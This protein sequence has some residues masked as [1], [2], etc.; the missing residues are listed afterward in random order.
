LIH[1]NAPR[2]AEAPGFEER[3]W[4][5]GGEV[6]QAIGVRSVPTRSP[7]LWVGAIAAVGTALVYGI[8]PILFAYPFPGLATFVATL[9]STSACAVAACFYL[10]HR[11]SSQR[12]D[13]YL[14]L[15]F[16]VIALV[17][18]VLPLVAELVPHTQTIAFWTRVIA[19]TIVAIALCIAAWQPERLVRRWSFRKL[20]IVTVTLAA[21]VVAWTLLW[22]SALPAA[23]DGTMDAGDAII[24]NPLVLATRFA[25]TVVLLAGAIGFVRRGRRQRD[26][27]FDWLACGAVLMATARFHDFLFPSLHD[28]WVTTG[29]MLRVVGYWVVLA[30]LLQEVAELWRSRGA[31]AVDAER[32]RVA[33]EI[34]DGLAQ[35]LAYISTQSSLAAAAGTNEQQLA[36]LQQAADRALGEARRV[37]F[38]YGHS[39]DL[40]LGGVIAELSREIE[41]RYGYHVV[42]DLD[43]DIVV[44][45][46]TAHEVGRIANEAMVN[47]AR[48]ARP[49]RISARLAIAA[50]QVQLTVADDGD[51]MPLHA[52]YRRTGGFGLTTMRDR[53]QRLGGSYSIVSTPGNGT[54]VQIEVPRR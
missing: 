42:L 20:A 29:D 2:L 8:P 1:L 39:G 26:R 41:Q 22:Q 35:D 38:A 36:K 37:I 17:E 14:A 19:R 15:F 32:R 16:G 4:V 3:A 30:G 18:A 5:S 33:A 50:Q 45:S 27:V 28:D 9:S 51:G 11:R 6:V 7:V 53:A 10:R 12:T 23:V 47:A 49:K 54:T 52:G 40:R 46:H 25:G 24:R 34:H 21:V 43:D 13:H 48:H 31:D 44:D